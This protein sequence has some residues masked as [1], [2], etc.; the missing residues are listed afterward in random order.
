M[1]KRLCLALMGLA[2]IS[3]S[4]CH[5]K[6]VSHTQLTGVTGS[7]GVINI[8]GLK[9]FETKGLVFVTVKID[10][11]YPNNIDYDKS[12]VADELLKK[13]QALGAD[14]IVNIR[15]YRRDVRTKDTYVGLLPFRLIGGGF[16]SFFDSLQGESPKENIK[17][18]YE[19][20]GSA[21][22][23]KYTGT[24]MQG[25]NGGQWILTD[26]GKVIGNPAGEDSTVKTNSG[27]AAK[28]AAARKPAAKKSPL[29][30]E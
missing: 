5:L 23:I 12:I 3:L 13:A 28:A 16:K 1:S 15:I 29:I 7:Y 25:S 2:F 20:H 26:A 17:H 21:M 18:S 8:A 30:P 24:V 4:A 9:T 19:Y 27:D 10:D 11:N 6:N 22:A 14:D